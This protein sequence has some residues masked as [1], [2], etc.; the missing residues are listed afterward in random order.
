[1]NWKD[2]APP[3][4]QGCPLTQSIR[5]DSLNPVYVLGGRGRTD[6]AEGVLERVL[7]LYSNP[8]PDMAVCQ[9]LS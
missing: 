7:Q 8:L 2:A 5:C 3:L 6:E 9:R 1:M 4:Q